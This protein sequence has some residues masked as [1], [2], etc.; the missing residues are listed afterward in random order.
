M[1]SVIVDFEWTMKNEYLHEWTMINENKKRIDI[2]MERDELV[3]KYSWAVPNQEAMEEIASIGKPVVEIGAGK[4]YWAYML[5]KNG[6]DIVAYDINPAEQSWYDVRLGGFS[7]L[8]RYPD[9]ILM[10]CW[11]PYDESMAM[12]C[13]NN[14]MGEYVTYIGEGYGGCTADDKFHEKLEDSWE[15]IKTVNIPVWWGINDNLTIWC[16]K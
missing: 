16:R 6:V 12:D 7:V 11:P 8:S 13:L 9:H 5:H 2:F 14:Y 3:K 15:L 10:L 4:G 1:T